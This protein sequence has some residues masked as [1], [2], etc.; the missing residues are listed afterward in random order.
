MPLSFENDIKPIFRPYRPN[1]LWR[2]DLGDYEQ[3][4]ANADLI[5]LFITADV[6]TRMPPANYGGPLSPQQIATFKQW[7][8]EGFPP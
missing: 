4:K 1:M 8:T 7:V 3:V 6:N 5:Q 2:F